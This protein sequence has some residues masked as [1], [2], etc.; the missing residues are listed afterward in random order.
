ME[1]VNET[2]IMNP[3]LFTQLSS[4]RGFNDMN[5]KTYKQHI[6]MVFEDS[7]SHEEKDKIMA[8]ETDEESL[9]VL[10]SYGINFTHEF[11]N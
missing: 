5:G 4:V 10:K 3:S 2:Y 7:L 11:K 1:E 9:E 8:T 6:L